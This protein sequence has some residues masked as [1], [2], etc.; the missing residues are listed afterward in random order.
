M[1]AGLKRISAHDTICKVRTLALTNNYITAKGAK[2]LAT[3]LTSST[4]LQELYIDW[5]NCGAE[6]CSHLAD[7]LVLNTSLQLLHLEANDTRDK[8]ITHLAK[9]LSNNRA[10]T[11]LTWLLTTS[12][13][14]AQRR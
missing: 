3:V 11:D 2:A 13:V 10:L 6:G 12:L 8:G 14:R 9:S 1:A 4:S 7:A 5:N